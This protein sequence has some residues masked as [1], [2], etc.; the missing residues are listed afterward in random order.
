MLDVFIVSLLFWVI[1]FIALKGDCKNPVNRWFSATAFFSGFGGIPV[2]WRENIIPSIGQNLSDIQITIINYVT[3]IISTFPYYLAPYAFFML[4]LTYSNVIHR[5]WKKIL[6][7][8]LLIPVCLMYIFY[9]VTQTF[10]TSFRVL[11]IWVVPYI[12]ISNILI[13]LV[14]IREKVPAIKRNKLYISLVTIPVTMYSL[15]CSYIVPAMGGHG[16]RYNFYITIFQFVAFMYILVNYGV[17]GVKLKFEKSNMDTAMKAITSSNAILNHTIKNQINKILMGID[18]LSANIIEKN[19]EIIESI[20]VITEST[21]HMLE[22]VKRIQ[23]KTSE[24]IL[25]EEYYSLYEIIEQSVNMVN[26]GLE[27]KGVI[28][29]KSCESDIMLY[30]DVVHVKEIIINILKNSFEAI[31]K[32]GRINIGVFENKNWIFIEIKD[33]GKGISKE[34]LGKVIQPFFSTK[35]NNGLNFG[36]GLSYCYNTMIKH[37]GFLE[38]KSEVNVGTSVYLNFPKE[39]VYRAKL[40]KS[41]QKVYGGI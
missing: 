39:K 23:E 18:N 15:T 37:K 22:M 24:I 4:G 30:C 14:F 36:L 31:E 21:N 25:I 9:P 26:S 27:N 11:C 1:A 12:I 32:E 3:A 10:R 33:N 8:I 13:F 20:E 5:K 2:V 38:I 35:S 7:I 6:A 34:Y 19:F 41:T 17:M 28:I 29:T 40:R 16:W